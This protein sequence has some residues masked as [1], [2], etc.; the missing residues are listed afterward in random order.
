[1]KEIRAKFGQGPGDEEKVSRPEIPEWNFLPSKA[2]IAR[3]G[4]R[5]RYQYSEAPV[6][7][8]NLRQPGQQAAQVSF[9][10][11]FPP[12]KAATVNDHV[13]FFHKCG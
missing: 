4:V 12:S 11:G 7:R 10:S 8:S 13:L 9:V 5:A 2:R 3:A 6:G 1:M